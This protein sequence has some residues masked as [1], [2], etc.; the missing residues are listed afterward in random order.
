MMKTHHQKDE[1]SS[2]RFSG[3]IHLGAALRRRLDRFH[4][5]L[6]HDHRSAGSNPIALEQRAIRSAVVEAER[7][8][9]AATAQLARYRNAL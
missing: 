2:G 9:A 4:A 6:G 7:A 5:D 3:I 8:R 1:L